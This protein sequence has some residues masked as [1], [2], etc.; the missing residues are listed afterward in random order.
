MRRAV[1]VLMAIVVVACFLTPPVS[2]LPYDPSKP[3]LTRYENPIG[4]TA[5]GAESGWA[6]PIKS[7]IPN[8]ENGELRGPRGVARPM[9]A[10]PIWKR[11]Y[12]FLW[13]IQNGLID[14]RATNEIGSEA[15]ISTSRTT[16][17]N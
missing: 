6:D 5:A 1:F 14:E 13:L 3:S 4:S 12:Y 16:S 9:Y 2:A 15:A 8:G 7:A 10:C 17:S 11:I